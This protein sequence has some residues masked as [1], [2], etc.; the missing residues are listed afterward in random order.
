MPSI[1]GDIMVTMDVPDLA[2]GSYE[3][4]M[5]QPRF[6]RAVRAAYTGGEDVLDA[7]WWL[8]HPDEP[9]PT[10]A[11]GPAAAV[12][13]AR[14]A[15]YARSVP[16]FAL[17]RFRA[18]SEHEIAMRSAILSALVAVGPSRPQTPAPRRVVERFGGPGEHERRTVATGRAE[19]VFL[20]ARG[21]PRVAP[22]IAVPRATLYAVQSDA[23]HACVVLITDTGT[24]QGNRVPLAEF[25]QAGIELEVEPDTAWEI[26]LVRA[27]WLP[28]GEVHWSTL[29][30]VSA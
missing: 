17:E 6:L 30:D 26:D 10:G 5:A 12:A 18:A 14:R 24:F 7:L 19:D 9:G 15:L 23:G 28:T 27:R 1:P 29:S 21:W 13:E 22:L 8:E 16:A 3:R 2:M 4:A 25:Q 11:V 20:R